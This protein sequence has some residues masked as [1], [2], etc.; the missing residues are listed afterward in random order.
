MSAAH[1]EVLNVRGVSASGEGVARTQDGEVVFVDGVF[2]GDVVRIEVV[3]RRKGVLRGRLVEVVEGSPDRVPSA[4]D[5][6]SCGGCA[7]RGLDLAAQRA[8]KHARLLDTMRRIGKLRVE[9]IAMPFLGVG[10]GWRYRHRVRLHAA[11]TAQGWMLGYR[12]RRSH[13]IV[14]VESCPVLWPELDDVVRDLRRAMRAVPREARLESVRLAWSRHDGAGAAVLTV[15]HP[16]DGHGRW[17][18]DL[19]SRGRVVGLSIV[20]RRGAYR[21][22]RTV[23]R[24]DHGLPSESFVLHFEPGVFTQAH[25]AAN[26]HLVREVLEACRPAPG[27]RV[28]ELHAGVGN[29]TLPLVREGVEVTATEV[30]PRAVRLLRRNLEEAGVR[31]TVERLSDVEAVGRYG[32]AR[33]QRT[34]DVVVLDP[35]RRGARDA[36]VRLVEV[37]PRRVVYVSCDPA[38][39]ARDAKVLVAGGYRLVRLRGLD[40][41]PQ[42]PHVE[43]VATFVHFTSLRAC[44]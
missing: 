10:E 8:L 26:P 5:V 6:T 37:R 14:P 19:L 16:W 38:T 20:S 34:W 9:S 43:A 35:P 3:G 27:S 24:Y 40:F 33:G 39:L 4:C 42:T 29:L 12:G 30:D 31:A 44:G 32:G 36:V 41:F 18:D 23:L 7:F 17:S 15:G 11:W 13:R 25:P 28:L 21:S 2:P 1:I 22:G